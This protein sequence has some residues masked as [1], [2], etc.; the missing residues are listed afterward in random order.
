[1][2][3]IYNMIS[4]SN[5]FKLLIRFIFIVILKNVKEEEWESKRDEVM[6]II[7]ILNNK[8]NVLISLISFR[9]NFT[10]Q[11]KK[12]WLFIKFVINI[13]ILT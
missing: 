6:Y 5:N 4:D 11:G 13:I 8:L 3:L 2:F 10:L 1:M 9:Y 7:M 12:I